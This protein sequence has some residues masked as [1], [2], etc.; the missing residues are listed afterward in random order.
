MNK[1]RLNRR[2]AKL[3]IINIDDKLFQLF[4][5]SQEEAKNKR[6]LAEKSNDASYYYGMVSAFLDIQT[7]ILKM[8]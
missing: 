7:K 6:L 2:K 3:P 5:Y 1:H 8:R 4:D